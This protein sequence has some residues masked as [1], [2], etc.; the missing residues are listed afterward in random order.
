MPYSLPAKIRVNN[1]EQAWVGA[2]AVMLL[3]LAGS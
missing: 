1:E 2:A 3:K